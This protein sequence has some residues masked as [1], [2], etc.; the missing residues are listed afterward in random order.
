MSYG[1]IPFPNSNTVN[2][3]DLS[4]SSWYNKA[5]VPLISFSGAI[6]N[7]VE[8]AL[9]LFQRLSK[10]V[11][12]SEH[13]LVICR[14]IVVDKKA[15]LV[16]VC[17]NRTCLEYYQCCIITLVSLQRLDTKACLKS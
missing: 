5:S 7:F 8:I 12:C 9:E 6:V 1:A 15:L 14:T 17:T 3:F 4:S 10:M 16:H 2:H 11:V 13:A